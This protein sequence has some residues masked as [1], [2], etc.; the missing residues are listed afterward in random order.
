VTKLLS[1]D[2]LRETACKIMIGEENHEAIR[3]FP[4]D[5]ELIPQFDAFIDIVGCF[6]LRLSVMRL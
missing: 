2:V 4:P 5:F 6:W 3:E 1:S